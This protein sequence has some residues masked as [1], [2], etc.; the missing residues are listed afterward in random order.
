M[1]RIDR[2]ETA[3]RGRTVR[4]L[5]T[6]CAGV[7]MSGRPRGSPEPYHA[8]RRLVMSNLLAFA[9][10]TKTAL[11]LLPGTTLA[12]WMLISAGLAVLG[13]LT[14]SETLRRTLSGVALVTWGARELTRD[15]RLAG[16][17]VLLF[18]MIVAL[19]GL[20]A[21]LRR[22]PLATPVLAVLA[23]AAVLVLVSTVTSP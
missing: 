18:V 12:Q 14:G 15:P 3:N 23:V 16:Q 10:L 4:A 20:A 7:V 19:Y 11:E 1:Q 6:S 21:L 8:L 5:H 17:F 22:T 9:I 13:G 2:R